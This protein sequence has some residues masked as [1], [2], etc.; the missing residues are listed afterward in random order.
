MLNMNS[1]VKLYV[2]TNV[3]YTFLKSNAIV[4]IATNKA[5]GDS[6]NIISSEE[7]DNVASLNNLLAEFSTL[8]WIWKNDLTSK[9]VGFFHYRRYLMVNDNKTNFNKDIEPAESCGF[10]NEFI[11]NLFQQYDIVIPRPQVLGASVYVQYCYCHE[12]VYIDQLLNIISRKY[13]ELFNSFI[14]AFQ[15]NAGY[16]CNLFI[17][18]RETFD[19]YMEFIF[20]IFNEM[21]PAISLSRQGKPFAYLCERIFCGYVQYLRDIKGFRIKEVPVLYVLPNECVVKHTTGM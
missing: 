2:G 21:K 15:A 18:K 7:G 17:M 5:L 14:T 20:D 13:P 4:P 6:I 9:Y 12:Q 1:D 19:E 8:Y 3:P 16:Y 10:D 11:K